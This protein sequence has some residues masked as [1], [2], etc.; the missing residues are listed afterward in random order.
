MV[1]DEKLADRIRTTLARGEDAVTERKMFGGICFLVDGAM[2]C[3]VL[4]DELIVKVGPE[5][6]DKA[7]AKPHTR[8][9]DFTGRPM[10][11]M[12]Y[13]APGGTRTA[14]SLEKWLKLGVAHARAKARSTS[15]RRRKR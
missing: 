8:P 14:A 6:G 12:L 13:V 2:C 9:F 1:F 7:L 10:A 15:K 11:G 5:E 3:G 4:K